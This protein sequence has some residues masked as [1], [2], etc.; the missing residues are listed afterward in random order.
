MKYDKYM[1]KECIALC[2]CLNELPHTKT[3]ESCCGHLRQP[4][5]IWFRCSSFTYLA[6][7]ARA[8]DRRYAGTEQIWR[9]TAETSDRHPRFC[10]LLESEYAYDSF[11]AMDADTKRII[12]NIHYW[13]DNFLEYFRSNGA[14]TS[15]TKQ[16]L[17]LTPEDIKEIDEWIC[18][19]QTDSDLTGRELYEEVLRRFNEQ[20]EKK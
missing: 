19:L 13:R 17:A 9:L 10:F 5:R 14:V 6:I 4:F 1:D 15:P 7:I 8:I 16:V 3:E 2:D 12:D 18:V 20:R 11:E